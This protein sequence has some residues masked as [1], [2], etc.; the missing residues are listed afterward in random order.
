[1]LHE[2]TASEGRQTR[3][4]RVGRWNGSKW[5]TCGKWN[6]GQNARSWWWVAAWF[7]WGQT[8]LFMRLPKLRG[9]K[10]YFKLLK[11][12]TP[13][14]LSVLES[15]KNID[16]STPITQDLLFSLGMI[17]SKDSTPKILGDWTLTKSLTIGEWVLCSNSAKKAI[18]NAWGSVNS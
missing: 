17:K 13:V 3:A 8:P 14:N 16:S 11:D 5:N 4:K 10:R 15:S 18:E 6:K 7:E 9:F 2:L 12:V 1:M